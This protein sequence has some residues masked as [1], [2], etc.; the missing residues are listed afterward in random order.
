VLIVCGCTCH[1]DNCVRLFFFWHTLLSLNIVP[2]LLLYY[3]MPVSI[4]LTAYYYQRPGKWCTRVSLHTFRVILLSLSLRTH[5]RHR[6]PYK[7]TYT[8]TNTHHTKLIVTYTHPHT[9][10]HTFPPPHTHPPTHTSL[11]NL[12][13]ELT[14]QNSIVSGASSWASICRWRRGRRSA[15]FG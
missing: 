14:P 12:T 1:H 9:P 4:T 7:Y 6:F 3:P 13:L 11:H 15:V 2:C 5:T 8:Q 10:P